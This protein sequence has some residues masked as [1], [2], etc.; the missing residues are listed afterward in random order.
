MKLPKKQMVLVVQIY[1]ANVMI[2]LAYHAL[3]VQMDHITAG[4]FKKIKKIIKNKNFI[5]KYTNMI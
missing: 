3:K 2:T 5:K 1:K 4:Q